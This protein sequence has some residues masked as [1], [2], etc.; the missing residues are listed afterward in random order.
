MKTSTNVV[1][2]RQPEDID[3]PLTEV[4]RV[5]ACRLLVQAVGVKVDAFLSDAGSET[6]G[7]TCPARAASSR[8]GADDP[9]GY[10]LGAGARVRVRDCG[11]SGSVDRVQFT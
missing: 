4:L 11:A 8:A 2:L 5:G 1:R 7:W 3:D 6:T 10:V 9:D